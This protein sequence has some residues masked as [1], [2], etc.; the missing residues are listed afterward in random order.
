ML[1]LELAVNVTKSQF[2][3]KLLNLSKFIMIAS[4]C[5]LAQKTTPKSEWW[6][7]CAQCT[8]TE[9][10]MVS[11]HC[12][13]NTYCAWTARWTRRPSSPC[14]PVGS[15]QR[16]TKIRISSKPTGPKGLWGGDLTWKRGLS[17]CA[18]PS[19]TRSPRVR[20][21]SSSCNLFSEPQNFRDS[22]RKLS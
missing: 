16:M 18:V 2:L 1:Q 4:L 12:L 9:H 21:T 10:N 15:A 11:G 14:S 3:S 20:F 6:K 19:S 8:N 22:P 17:R 13:D 5:V 7:L